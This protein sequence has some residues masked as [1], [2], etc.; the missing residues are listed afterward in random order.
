MK[1][2]KLVKY[3]WVA[4]GT[5]SWGKTYWKIS[6]KPKFSVYGALSNLRRKVLD[7]ATTIAIFG[8]ILKPGQCKK[9]EIREAK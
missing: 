6:E 2:K 9:F 7:E 1:T 8:N 5:Q 3:F 4:R